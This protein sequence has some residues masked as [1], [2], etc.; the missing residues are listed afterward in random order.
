MK[1][2]NLIILVILLSIYFFNPNAIA[3]DRKG[4]VGISGNLQTLQTDFSI[5]IWI[6]NNKVFAPSFGL[7]S[8]SDLAI[9]L[10]LG[11]T[12]RI[13]KSTEKLSPNYGLRFACLILKPHDKEEDMLFDFV[14]GIFIGTEYF[15][16]E[17]FSIGGEIQLNCSLSDETSGRFGNPDGYI[18]NT[19]MAIYATFYFK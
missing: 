6:A 12:Y 19:G 4:K 14:S 7:L 16:D 3:E 8:V 15:F 18:I 9:D 1:Q 2:F 13:Y 5:P 11:G 17:K 10:T